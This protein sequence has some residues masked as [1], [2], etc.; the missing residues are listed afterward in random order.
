MRSAV[1]EFAKHLG[2]VDV[3]RM[4]S[5]SGSNGSSTGAAHG[6]STLT[7]NSS[8]STLSFAGT[9]TGSATADSLVQSAGAAGLGETELTVRVEITETVA[10]TVSGLMSIPDATAV[11]S[12]ENSI[13]VEIRGGPGD[14]PFH[15]FLQGEGSQALSGFGTIE[16]GSYTF[17]VFLNSLAESGGADPNRPAND[18]SSGS[19]VFNFFVS[20]DATPPPTP[21]PI[22][23]NN[24]AGG[25]FQVAENGD[26]LIVPGPGDTAV[27]GLQ[28]VYDVDVGTAQ[29][30]RLEIRNGDVTFTNANYSVASTNFLPSGTVLDNSVLTLASG[31]LAGIHILI[32]ESA[33]ARVDVLAGATLNYT[34]SL[35][36]GGPGEGVMN[37][38]DGGHVS[39]GSENW[40]RG[41]RRHCDDG[42]CRRVV[43]ERQSGRWFFCRRGGKPLCQWRGTAP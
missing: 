31:T 27:F 16:P 43:G 28:T 19:V 6:G 20:P 42:R 18:H 9:I 1:R 32:G 29:T 40:Y 21:T 37:I 26:P 3:E 35:Q 17:S 34:G 5:S 4:S 15:A 11:S 25:S 36:V 33:A 2:S 24:A 13:E 39:A 12:A 10:F 14:A 23:W 7:V 38:A 8:A 30:E 22:Q 41:R